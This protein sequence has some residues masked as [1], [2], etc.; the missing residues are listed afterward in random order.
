MPAGG[1]NPSGATAGLPSPAFTTA[2]PSILK[3]RSNCISHTQNRT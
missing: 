1:L 3:V 2:N